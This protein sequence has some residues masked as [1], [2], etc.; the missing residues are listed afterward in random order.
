MDPVPKND[1]HYIPKNYTH[2]NQALWQKGTGEWKQDNQWRLTCFTVQVRA[3]E[4]S[5]HSFMRQ[6]MCPVLDGG[7]EGCGERICE[8]REGEE[9][10]VLQCIEI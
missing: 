1:V 5:V 7:R 6:L 10:E 3:A 9:E 8:I 4:R 2:G